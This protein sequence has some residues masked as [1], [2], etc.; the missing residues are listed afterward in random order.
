VNMILD[1]LVP[2]CRIHPFIIWYEEMIVM[3][4][5]PLVMWF[6]SVYTHNGK[7]IPLQ[8]I[9]VVICSLFCIYTTDYTSHFASLMNPSICS[10]ALEHLLLLWFMPICSVALENWLPCSIWGVCDGDYEEYSLLGCGAMWSLHEPT[11]RRKVSPP[12]SG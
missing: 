7:R 11:F 3:A 8:G 6:K 10:I 5:G 1:A 9:I 4:R 2:T 12:S